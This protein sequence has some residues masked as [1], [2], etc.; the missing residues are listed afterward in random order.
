[1]SLTTQQS[2]S[3]EHRRF[4]AETTQF[5]VLLFVLPPLAEL[6]LELP[7]G[8][9][10][11]AWLPPLALLVPPEKDVLAVAPP[12]ANTSLDDDVLAVAPPE[13]NASLDD[14]VLP[15]PWPRGVPPPLPP[16]IEWVLSRAVPPDAT[17]LGE[18]VVVSVAIPPVPEAVPP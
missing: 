18:K 11:D 3:V 16:R 14:G 5:A 17:V 1:M 12:E 8:L 10:D 13:P 2:A 4:G 9:D 7:F 6:P 15:A